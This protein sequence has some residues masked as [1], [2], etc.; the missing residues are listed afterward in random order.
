MV[1]I[2]NN[3]VGSV[4]PLPKPKLLILQSLL[5]FA[6]NILTAHAHQLENFSNN[7]AIK[8]STDMGL[9][10]LGLVLSPL[11][12]IGTILDNSRTAVRKKFSQE[13]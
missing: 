10:F 5:F 13:H 4:R 8:F 6:K 7:V 2:F 9:W 1:K 12:N 3:C 11:L